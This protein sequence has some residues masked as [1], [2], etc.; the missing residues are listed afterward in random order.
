M[1]I[2]NV[3]DYRPR[4]A[5]DKLRESAKRAVL[6][7]PWG[8]ERLGFVGV[9]D[10][11]DTG[12]VPPKAIIKGAMSGLVHPQGLALNLR[13]KELFVTDSARNMTFTFSA[14]EFFSKRVSK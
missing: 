11:T 14:P 7:S 4:Y 10:I 13:D 5:R 2:G 8:S 6:R 9:W 3:I 12:D 1:A